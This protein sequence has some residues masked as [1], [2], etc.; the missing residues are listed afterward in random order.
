MRGLALRVQCIRTSY[1][2]RSH[3]VFGIV[4]REKASY[5]E[6]NAEERKTH[7]VKTWRSDPDPLEGFPDVVLRTDP[8]KTL[9]PKK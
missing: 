5:P 3:R 8:T 9:N 1:P 2:F 6:S 4:V 7:V